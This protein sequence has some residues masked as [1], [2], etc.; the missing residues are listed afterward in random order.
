MF[1]LEPEKIEM[2]GEP[3]TLLKAKGQQVAGMAGPVPGVPNHW[4]VFFC[5]QDVDASQKVAEGAGGKTLM[6]A[7]DT[8]I[9]KMAAIADPQ[10]AAF[11]IYQPH[12]ETP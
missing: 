6:G 11:M 12:D 9:G 1:G 5:V 10:G 7:F 3:Y 2:G 4:G 8:P